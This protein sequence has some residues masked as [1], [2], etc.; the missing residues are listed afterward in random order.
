MRIRDVPMK[1]KRRS[2]EKH[3]GPVMVRPKPLFYA[4]REPFVIS[5]GGLF[6]LNKCPSLL[7]FGPLD[8]VHKPNVQIKDSA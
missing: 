7:A 5:V 3:K 6:L 8:T 2:K 4:I 1:V